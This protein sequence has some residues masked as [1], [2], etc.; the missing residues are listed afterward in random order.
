MK[1]NN[2]VNCETDSEDGFEQTHVQTTHESNSYKNICWKGLK[3]CVE[4]PV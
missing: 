2:D 4:Q 1:R 3:T